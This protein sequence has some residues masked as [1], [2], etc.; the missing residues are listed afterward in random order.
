MATLQNHVLIDSLTNRIDFDQN[1]VQIKSCPGQSVQ[2]TDDQ[3]NGFQVATGGAVSVLGG[4]SF[5]SPNNSIISS[6]V[7]FTPIQMQTL[8]NT[9]P[10]QMLPAP[11]SG[12]TYAILFALQNTFGGNI[13]YNNLSSCSI[14]NGTNLNDPEISG[15]NLNSGTV[16]VWAMHPASGAVKASSATLNQ[17]L[18]LVNNNTTAPTQGNATVQFTLYYFLV[19]LN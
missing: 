13:S 2:I 6:Q 18:N 14:L 5:P 12:L 11:A 9:S 1:G 19:S 7:T 8:T 16:N 17:P 10:L 15:M 3:G 4:G